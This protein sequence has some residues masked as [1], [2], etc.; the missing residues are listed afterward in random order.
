MLMP[1]RTKYRKPH[2]ECLKGEAKGGT[3]VA[4]GEFGIQALE[5]AYITA[6][7]IEV[8]RVAMNRKMRKG[9]KMWIRIRPKGIFY[10]PVLAE[11]ICLYYCSPVRNVQLFDVG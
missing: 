11:D 7:Q 8:T 2:R 3:Y 1:K 9:G 4:F 5:C 6:R 10:L